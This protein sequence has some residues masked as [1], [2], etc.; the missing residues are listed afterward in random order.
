MAET[1]DQTAREI[2][3]VMHEEG[4]IPTTEGYPDLTTMRDFQRR[5]AQNGYPIDD[6]EMADL[7]TKYVGIS[8]PA[9]H[10]FKTGKAR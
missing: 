8:A 3:A 4:D 5:M 7:W 9:T 2:I 1:I 10:D 6:T